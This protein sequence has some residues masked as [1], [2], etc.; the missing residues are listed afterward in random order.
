MHIDLKRYSTSRESTL[1]LLSVDGVFEC[2]TIEDTQR[3]EK[4]AGET[5]IPSGLYQIHLRREGGLHNKYT[6][7]YNFHR[8]MLW[9]QDVPGFTFV[10]IHTGN[11][12]KHTEG[13]ILLGDQPNNNQLETGFVGKS[14]DAYGRLYRGLAS[15]AE[16]AALTIRIHDMG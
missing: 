11:T 12:R 1:G 14:R 10:Y 6:A 9:L 2:Y 5:R 7:R 13:C 8:G 16:G 15:A 4:I 3:Y